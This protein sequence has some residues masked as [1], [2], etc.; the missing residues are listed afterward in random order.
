VAV[1]LDHPAHYFSPAFRLLAEN[2]TIDNTVYYWNAAVEGAMDPGFG[3]AVRWEG[4][5]HSGYRW[6]APGPDDPNWRRARRVL[7]ALAAQRPQVILCFGW[8]SPIAR[9]AILFATVTGTPLLY[10][11]D[12]NPQHSRY[13]RVRRPILR[14]LFRRAAGSLTTGALN[15]EFYLAHGL[16]PDRIHP[17]VL[18][19]DVAA[20]AAA[21]RSRAARLATTNEPPVVI[22]FAGKL[23]VIKGVDDLIRAAARLPGRDRWEL[24]LVGDGPLRPRLEALV[25]ECGITE[26]VR[27]LGFR[28]SSEMPTLMATCDIVVVPSHREARGLVAVEAMAAGAAT[29]VSSATG[30]WGPGDVLQHDLSGLVFAAKDVDALAAA[31]Q[32]LIDDPA[33]R[34]RLA[35]AGRQRA[36]SCGPEAFAATA[37]T[38]L[39]AGAGRPRRALVR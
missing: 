24:R 21:G 32:R 25:E 23:I 37:A 15:R 17:G 35:D 26:R 2:R 4:D 13:D 1:L 18:P 9:L 19:T 10:Y 22:G 33:L 6:W 7:H 20:F 34:Q 28:D 31:L 12:T 5:L 14:T 16:Q 27:F 38:A 30:V 11:G 8:G 3:R 36:M 39:S 29:V